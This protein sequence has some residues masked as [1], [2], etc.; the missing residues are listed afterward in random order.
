M[1]IFEVDEKFLKLINYA[2]G[3]QLFNEYDLRW[4]STIDALA[5][6][7]RKMNALNDFFKWELEAFLHRKCQ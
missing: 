3:L 5:F 4:K 7:N 6:L 1:V 2:N